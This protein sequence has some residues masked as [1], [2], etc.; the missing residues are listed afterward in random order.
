[1]VR[2]NKRRSRLPL[3][4]TV[5]QIFQMQRQVRAE[6]DATTDPKKREEL[7]NQ[8]QALAA[9]IRPLR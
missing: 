3:R 1:M 5:S 9:Q 6:L 4:Y 7:Q 8:L 2:I